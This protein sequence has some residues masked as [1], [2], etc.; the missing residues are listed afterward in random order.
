[1]LAVIPFHQV[2]ERGFECRDDG[3]PILV[4]TV[5]G[6]LRVLLIEARPDCPRSRS[7]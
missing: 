1:M 3:E 2:T 6:Q 4:M 7:P 5:A